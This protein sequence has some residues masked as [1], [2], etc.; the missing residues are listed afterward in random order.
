VE[1]EKVLAKE[2]A[3]GEWM[4]KFTG[5]ATNMGSNP[6]SQRAPS[7]P[8][9]LLHGVG[10]VTERC[11]FL[12]TA[13]STSRPSLQPFPSNPW[14]AYLDE[15]PKAKTTMAKALDDVVEAEGL[16]R[17]VLSLAGPREEMLRQVLAGQENYERSI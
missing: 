10:S 3:N 9:T 11:E 6:C 4:K 14:P 13:L 12:S 2:H 7:H 16:E 15:I 17:G 5:N 8:L 1:S